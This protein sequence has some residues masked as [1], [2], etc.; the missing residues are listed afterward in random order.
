MLRHVITRGNAG[1]AMFHDDVDYARYVELLGLAARRF[2]VV[3]ESY[4]LMRTHVHLVL[5]PGALSLSR[6]MQQLNSQYCQWFNRRHDRFGHVTGG[7]FKAPFVDTELYYLRLIRYVLMNPVVAGYVTRAADWRWSSYAA[8]RTGADRN[9]FV[10][11]EPV[12][13]ALGISSPETAEQ[14][15][16][17]FLDDSSDDGFPEEGYLIGSQ[18]FARQFE[19]A[20][21]PARDCEDYVRAERFAARPP[22]HEVVS[23]EQPRR[24]CGVKQAFFEW[25]YTLRE[26]GR[27]LGRTTATIWRWVHYGRSKARAVARS[28]TNSPG[29]GDHT[30]SPPQGLVGPRLETVTTILD[31]Y[32]FEWCTR[33]CA[34]TPCDS[35]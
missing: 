23:V 18:A 7:R 20:L 32:C 13:R 31:G 21:R 24:E 25:A 34:G 27:Y 10:S 14:T 19:A 33:F 17:A 26:I 11:I 12:W 30:H 5:R 9:Q 15:L 22:L 3:C 29:R 4:C 35:S 16:P 1:E 2:G 6:M 8:L 28:N